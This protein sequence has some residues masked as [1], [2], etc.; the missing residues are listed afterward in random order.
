MTTFLA[1]ADIFACEYK[2]KVLVID[3]DPQTNL[4]VSLIR[5]S[6]WK[7]RDE[8]GLTLKQLFLDAQSGNRIFDPQ[9]AIVKNVSNIIKRNRRFGSASIQPWLD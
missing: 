8:K 5:D 6:D 9:K 2:F 4:T 3:L 1:L 7:E